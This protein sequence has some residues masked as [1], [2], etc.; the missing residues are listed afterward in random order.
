MLCILRYHSRQSVAACNVGTKQSCM[1]DLAIEVSSKSQKIKNDVCPVLKASNDT[2]SKSGRVS[3]PSL[4]SSLEIA[5]NAGLDS[6]PNFS[7]CALKKRGSLML[8][9]HL[10]QVCQRLACG[11][12][13]WIGECQP[14]PKA[15]LPL[16][17]SS[18]CRR[19][20]PGR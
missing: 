20:C 13:K 12:T 3:C 2:G 8:L 11:D 6:H 4:C 18:A 17:S 9:S 1:T 10:L 19:A 16:W 14:T 7:C 15:W 5:H